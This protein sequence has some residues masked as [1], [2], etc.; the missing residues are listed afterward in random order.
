MS[1]KIQSIVSTSK[2]RFLLVVTFLLSLLL[3]LFG[4]VSAK[5]NRSNSFKQYLVQNQN[6]RPLDYGTL[7]VTY[8][9][10]DELDSV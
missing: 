7:Y 8:K 1:D 3:Y 6:T 10:F 4:V 9:S 2:K 5:S